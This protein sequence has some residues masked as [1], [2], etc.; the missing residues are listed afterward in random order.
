MASGV[1]KIS[2]QVAGGQGRT[3][4]RIDHVAVDTE[5]PRETAEFYEQTLGATVVAAEGHPVMAYLG[6]TAFAFHE[7]GGP[8]P[9]AAV[10]VTS[11]ERAAI[12]R[13][14]DAAG[15]PNEERDHGIA[16][17]LF[18]RDPDGRLL[19]AITYRGVDDP[20]RPA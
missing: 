10:R 9:H 2:S 5:R 6:A 4:A 1:A 11:E 3:M 16:V 12:A 18:F 15:I 13:R 20:R 17:G 8:G 7:P 14:L 19:E